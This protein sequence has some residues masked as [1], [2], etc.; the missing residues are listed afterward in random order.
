MLIITAALTAEAGVPDINTN[1][2][3]TAIENREAL[4]VLPKI[5]MT[6]PAKN[7]ICRPETATAC[8]SPALDIDWYRET[9]L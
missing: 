3:T 1:N 8:I 5:N 4:L 2:Q 9:S 6:A 7:E